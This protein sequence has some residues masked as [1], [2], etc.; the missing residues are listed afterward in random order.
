MTVK[1]EFHPLLSVLDRADAY[2]DQHSEHTPENELIQELVSKC[3]TLQEENARLK[4]A[5]VLPSTIQDPDSILS[6]NQSIRHI[7]EIAKIG[8]YDWDML[9]GQ[10]TC[11]DIF[12]DIFGLD[13][14]FNTDADGWR[15]I[16][17]VEWLE[18]LREHLDY[19]TRTHSKFIIEFKIIHRQSKQSKWML[20]VGEMFFD[21]AGQ[22]LRLIG[23][24]IDVTDHKTAEQKVAENEKL[25]RNT[26]AVARLGTY[27]WDMHEGS[28]V[29]SEI[30]DEIFGID[31]N[32]PRTFESWLDIIHPDWREQMIHYVQNEVIGK[33]KRFDKEYV[34]VHQQTKHH[35]W[36][37]GM[38]EVL[39]NEANNPTTLIGT[40]SDISIRKRTEIALQLS[41]K[42]YKRMFAANPLPMW[43]EDSDS[44]KFLRVNEAA[45]AHYGYSRYE[46]LQ[47]T[48]RDLEYEGEEHLSFNVDASLN[49]ND[50]D[51]NNGVRRHKKKNGEIIWV[52]ISWHAME[53]E[54]HRAKHVLINDV[55][56]SIKVQYQLRQNEKELKEI[57]NFA[58]VNMAIIDENRQV[59]YA[60]ESFKFFF[61]T[62]D[63][64]V[65]LQSPGSAFGCANELKDSRGCG[66]SITCEHCKLKLGIE[67]TFSTGVPHYNIDYALSVVEKGKKRR[68][69]LLASTA[70]IHFE[71]KKCVFLCLYD[72]SERALMESALQKSKQRYQLISE[73]IS[74]G[75]FIT[76]GGKL[77]FVNAS[78]AELLGMSEHQLL[79]MSLSHL[80]DSVQAAKLDKLLS[81]HLPKDFT[82]NMEMEYI[83]SN[84][85]KL[86]LDIKLHYVANENAVYGVVHNI[87]KKKQEQERRMLKAIVI[88]EEKER[89]SFSR[90]LHDGIGP[91]LSINKLYLD[92]L[93]RAKSAEVRAEII[94]KKKEIL[95]EAIIAVK[96]IS[97]KLSPHML[98]NHGITSAIQSYINKAKQTD[99]QTIIS[100][101]SNCKS[102]FEMEIEVALYRAAVESINNSLKYANAKNIS[103]TL[104][105]TLYELQLEFKDD[106]VGFDLETMLAEQKGLG[107]Y[108]IQ[109]RIRSIN[110]VVKM[111]SAVGEGVYYQFI[112]PYR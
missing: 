37:H 84:G 19:V 99:I 16:L 93:S 65:V 22:P 80:F 58:P 33:R 86:S 64:D 42:R 75:I 61:E 43:I 15:S 51:N 26:Q 56:A 34:I 44:L 1:D 25:L 69:S 78:M 49:F 100:F 101:E 73:S 18:R 10:W 63:T 41:E 70:L 38:G 88:T 111:E 95:D 54:G 23:I 6:I 17:E 5:L 45:A 52:E 67:E 14:N 76:K 36:V 74:D 11:S 2:L 27:V 31:H 97:N 107:L 72:I 102:R 7:N 21:E 35:F 20:A 94:E 81:M 47:L 50:E 55:T 29:G 32:Y 103:I 83:Q 104:K 112:I 4:D 96:E 62:S 108:N 109:N 89:E 8:T 12:L 40:I 87:T 48:S 59:Q 77:D 13:A 68:V 105:E 90:E 91:L 28:W 98:S 60:N 9:S 71:G 39:C 106:G 92:S 82:F 57:F 3:T 24:V 66:Y 53:F 110:G 85:G 79:G 30:L 46:F